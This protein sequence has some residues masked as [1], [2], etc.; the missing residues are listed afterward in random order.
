MRGFT[1]VELA[2][3]LAVAGLLISGVLGGAHL[4]KAAQNRSLI[5]WVEAYE[6]AIERFNERFKYLPGDFPLATTYWSGGVTAEAL[7]SWQH[8]SLARE[9]E[10]NFTGVPSPTRIIPGQNVP[11]APVGNG[12][13]VYSFRTHSTAIYN[14]TG[15]S[16]DVAKINS[17]DTDSVAH[18]GAFTAA[19]AENI[20]RK[21]DDGLASNGYIYASWGDD[22]STSSCVDN[23][24]ASSSATYQNNNATKSCRLHFWHDRR[25]SKE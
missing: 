20:D 17:P 25:R 3:V 18:F 13:I 6:G 19:D 15:H 9:I 1:L 14:F 22:F 4:R 2:I 21:A 5:A 16:I 11:V 7:R 23:S 8:L 24:I 12:D 10:T